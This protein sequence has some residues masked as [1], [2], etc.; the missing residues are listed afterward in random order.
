MNVEKNKLNL[1]DG[2]L[3]FFILLLFI[4]VFIRFNFIRW[5]DFPI[6]DGGLFFT[7][8][9]DLQDSH[10]QLPW[11]TTYNAAQIPYM[12]PPLGFYLAGFLNNLTK[13]DLFD[14]LLILPFTLSI[15]TIPA[16]YLLACEVLPNRLARIFAISAFIF[17]P[18][19]FRWLIM[20]GGLT[21]SLGLCSALLALYFVLM[22]YKNANTKISLPAIFFCGLTVLSHPPT[23]LFLIYS[24]VI[25][26]LC[27]NR[28]RKGIVQ[29]LF[30]FLGVLIMILPWLIIIINRHGISSFLSASNSG[31]PF[32]QN[33]LRLMLFKLSNDTFFPVWTIIGLIGFLIE[34]FNKRLFLPGWLLSVYLFQSRATADVAVIPLALLAGVGGTQ[35]ISSYTSSS[36]S[37]AYK[38]AIGMLLTGF[39]LLY[40]IIMPIIAPAQLTT[41]LPVVE[42]E[43]MMWIDTNTALSSSILVISGTD[44]FTDRSSEWLPVLAKRPSV[45][46]V[47]GYEWLDNFSIRVKNHAQL[48]ECATQGPDC[49]EKWTNDTGVKFSHLYVPKPCIDRYMADKCG[50][51]RAALITDSRY[52][53][54]YNRP[55]AAIFERLDH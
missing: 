31:Y 47:Q 40:S 29:S 30:L 33:V 25:I 15:L 37:H 38:K 48:E 24:I 26:F 36:I 50:A 5:A 52:R 46:V 16:F 10:Y 22:L 9:E 20:G 1:L 19:S 8:I 12:Y 54:V 2:Y 55:G 18:D 34:L 53:L 45:A 49:I 43:A 4:G 13:L 3:L 14:V 27:F 35:I 44:W 17:I 41:A 21:R 7:M 51:L 28:S 6:N 32:L 42:R 23:T 11:F 39:V